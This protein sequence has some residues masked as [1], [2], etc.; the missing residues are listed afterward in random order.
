MLGVIAF[1]FQMEKP[2]FQVP[3]FAM[4]IMNH[5]FQ[6]Y[7]HRSDKQQF[8]RTRGMVLWLHHLSTCLQ[9]IISLL[10]SDLRQMVDEIE[11]EVPYV[12]HAKIT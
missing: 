8:L 10:F 2:S 3:C 11:I 4:K 1:S 7:T 9:K 6:H 12:M 5:E